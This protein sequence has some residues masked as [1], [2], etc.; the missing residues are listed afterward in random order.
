M[1]INPNEGHL[2]PYVPMGKFT[3]KVEPSCPVGLAVLTRQ[4][5][6]RTLFQFVSP[7]ESAFP[8]RDVPDASRSTQVR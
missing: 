2:F 3:F 6:D 8:E 5:C 7:F 1:R 4:E